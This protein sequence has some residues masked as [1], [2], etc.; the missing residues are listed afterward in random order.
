[1]ST[2]A[3]RESL[4]AL[5]FDAAEAVSATTSSTTCTNCNGSIATT[6]HEANGQV[7]CA[8]CRSKLEAVMRGEGSGAGR[9]TRAFLFGALG[10]A[11]GSGIYYAVA[12]ITG[13]E[14]GLV[15][16]VVGWLVGRGVSMGAN[17]RGGWKYQALAIALTYIAIVTTYIPFILD[18]AADAPGLVLFITALVVPFAAGLKN[19]IGIAIIGFALFQAW[20][21]NKRLEIK[22]TGPYELKAASSPASA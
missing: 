10:A 17:H 18:E 7:V 19:I 20:S 16:I 1:M 8:S 3:T 5:T 6:Y 21:M 15:A 11:I 14:I 22:F 9:L 2:E 12:A 4:D 13:L